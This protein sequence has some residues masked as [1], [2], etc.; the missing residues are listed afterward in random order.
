M[1]NQTFFEIVYTHDLTNE[2][3]RFQC[4]REELKSTIEML[5]EYN[6]DFKLVEVIPW[7]IN[8]C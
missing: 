2:I 8:L 3:R 4:T 6:E 7:R 5:K 1:V